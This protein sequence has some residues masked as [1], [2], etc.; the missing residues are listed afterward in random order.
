MSSKKPARKGGKAKAVSRSAKAGLQFPV[1]RVARYLKNGRYAARV[2]AGAPV[3]LAAVLE[4]L[5]AEIL[6]LAGNA[7]RDNKKH[8]IV[9]RHV[10]LAVRNDEELNKLM[11]GVTI[12][13]G[14]V[15]PNIHAVLLPKKAAGKK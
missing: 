11:G 10:Q 4:Y 3:Y 2:G 1:G 5:A 6:E 15:L 9:P 13:Q 7:A 14:G 12:A 8:R